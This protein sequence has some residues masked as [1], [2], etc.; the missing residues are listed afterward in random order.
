MCCFSHLKAKGLRGVF[1]WMAEWQG[2]IREMLLIVIFLRFSIKSVFS[3]WS[4][5]AWALWFLN[6]ATIWALNHS[7]CLQ[8]KTLSPAS[9]RLE[10]TVYPSLHG[11]AWSSLWTLCADTSWN[12]THCHSRF[13][14]FSLNVFVLISMCSIVCSSC[15]Q[16]LNLM[17]FCFFQNGHLLCL[18]L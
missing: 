15:V 10:S 5:Q 18:P 4:V 14:V 8:M 7:V 12:Q 11:D 17:G 6:V 13:K 2:V 9:H 3:K 1:Q 16:P